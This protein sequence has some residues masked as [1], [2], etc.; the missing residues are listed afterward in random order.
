MIQGVVEYM[1]KYMGASGIPTHIGK[2]RSSKKRR[3]KQS[4]ESGEREKVRSCRA[5]E[6]FL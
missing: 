3:K 4:G 5:I 6:A 1:N 2:A